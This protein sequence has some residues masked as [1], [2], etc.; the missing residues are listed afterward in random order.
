MF[1]SNVRQV[2]DFP[3][4]LKGNTFRRLY[5]YTRLPVSFMFGFFPVKLDSYI[6]QPIETDSIS[7][8]RCRDLA[9]QGVETLIR[10]HQRYRYDWWTGLISSLKGRIRFRKK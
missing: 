4:R 7:V 2:F 9:M 8:E 1:T 6:G 10:K 5:E 3:D